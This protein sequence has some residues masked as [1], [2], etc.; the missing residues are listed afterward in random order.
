MTRRSTGQKCRDTSPWP[1]ARQERRSMNDTSVWPIRW[2][3]QLILVAGLATLS[4]SGFTA[5]HAD[6]VI[7]NLTIQR[8]WLDGSNGTGYFPKK[9]A[10]Y[11]LAAPFTTG[12]AGYKLNSVKLKFDSKVGSPT[13]FKMSLYGESSSNNPGT[14]LVDLS[15]DAPN[16]AGDYTYTCPSTSTGCNLTASTTYYLVASASGSNTSEEHAYRWEHVTSGEEVTT[17]SNNGWSIVDKVYVKDVLGNDTETV[18]WNDLGYTESAMFS[19][20]ADKVEL[21]SSDVE[22]DAATLSIMNRVGTWY[23]KRSVPT[24]GSC[25]EVSSGTTASLTSLSGGTSYTYKAYSDSSCSK[26]LTSATTDAEFLTK[27]AQVSGVTVMTLSGSLQVKWTAASGTVTGYKVQWKSGNEEYNTSDRQTT[28]TSGTTSTI[29]SLTNSTTYTIRVT[30]Y[31]A[32]G[33]GTASAG[34]TGTPAAVTLS[35]SAVEAATATLTIGNHLSKWYYKYTV[36]NGDS[37]CTEVL[38]GITTARLTSLTGGTSYTYKAYSDSSCG[39]ELTSVTTD[40]EFLTKPAQVSGVTVASRNTSLNVSWTAAT[41][42]VTGYKVQWKSG[43]DEY[44][45]TRQKTVTSGTTTSIT[46]LTNDTAYTVRVTAYNATGDGAASAEVTGTPAYYGWETTPPSSLTFYVGEA[47]SV[48]LPR[49]GCPGG[50]KYYNDS[51]YHLNTSSN[52]NAGNAGIPGGLSFR[53]GRGN[54][55]NSR[56]LSGSPTS[57][58]GPTTYYYHVLNSGCSGTNTINKATISIGVLATRA[59]LAPS[60]PNGVAGH[61]QVTLSFQAGSNGGAAI[62]SWQYAYKSA[63]GNYGAWTSMTSSSAATTSYTVTGL[64]NGTAYTFKVRAVNA[65]GN[66]DASPESDAVTPVT[67][68]P[69]APAKPTVALVSGSNTS[70]TLGWTAPNNG[71]STITGYK[72]VKKEGGGNFETTWTAIP[73][74][75]SLSSYTVTGLTA[76]RTSSKCLR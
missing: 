5:A 29:T 36:P 21:A 53:G 22:D 32:T 20:D 68:A 37:S 72:Y 39:T 48:T 60:K 3:R 49:W 23:Y 30:A 7:S 38:A 17:P 55:S 52:F 35:G 71:G 10:N 47:V 1:L 28:V 14:K 19:V 33:D 34:V 54:V 44:N 16:T 57:T 26:E 64:T 59:P 6:T 41:G 27:P 46:S 65:Q 63:G 51:Y 31:N 75:A 61:Q 66:G 25:T 56:L 76:R 69:A 62:T 45:A 24:A 58:Q 50:D 42:T 43:G 67:T 8:H 18:D 4:L 73:S 40:V 9:S 12:P 13:N 2:C 11:H 70:V 74:S 15:G